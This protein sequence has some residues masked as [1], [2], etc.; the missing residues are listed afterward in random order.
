MEE[1]KSSKGLWSQ[2]QESA[3]IIQVDEY[4]WVVPRKSMTL[5]EI[6]ELSIELTN[7]QHAIKEKQQ[8]KGQ[9]TTE[10]MWGNAQEG[11]KVEGEE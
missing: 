1:K 7:Q 10:P 11:W 9:Q 6:I 2:M 3:H 8:A 4:G 5:V